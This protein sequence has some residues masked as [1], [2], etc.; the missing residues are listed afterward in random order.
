M[1]E[2]TDMRSLSRDAR[3]E[4][5]V[6]V[7]RLRKAGQTYDEIAAQTGLSRTGVFD[8]CKRHDVAGAKA[9]RDAPSGR[10]SG[11]GRLLDAAQEALVRK[12]ITDKT[13]DQ[14]KMPYA[15]WTRAAVS[16]LIEQRFGIRLPVRTMGLYLARWGFTPQKP[17]KKAYEQSPAAVRKWLDEDYPVI[18]ARAKAEG[19]EI[20][21]GDES[22]LRSDDVR[23]RGFAP[24][25]QTP[26]IRVNSKRHGPV[27]DLHRDQQGPDALAHLR[28]RAQYE[29]PDR[30]PAP[31]DQGGEQEAVPDPGQPAGT[32]RQ[33]RQGV[34]G[35]ARR[36]DRGVL[37][38]QLQPRTQPRR[39][40]QR[41]HQ[42]SRHDAGASAHKAATGQG[43]RTPPS[44]R[45]APA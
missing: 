13:P 1:M 36:C 25:G 22:G 2:A 41:R 17:M 24:K 31:A 20:H 23:G 11:D 12:L 10:R 35:R 3:H 44:Q 4:R 6:Q 37:P 34:A 5:R 42:A 18:A 45:A 14:L 33:A 9:L 21:W 32:P 26:V 27:G 16:Q 15:L 7:I 38:A 30:L 28:R 19:A 40:G 43:H 8:I 39:N 29:H